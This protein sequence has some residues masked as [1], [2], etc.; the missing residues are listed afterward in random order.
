M[1]GL[2]V[3][4]SVEEPAGTAE[5]L[6]LSG[7]VATV[8]AAL[9]AQYA[10]SYAGDRYGVRGV[11]G[12]DRACL[13]RGTLTAVERMAHPSPGSVLRRRRQMI[14]CSRNFAC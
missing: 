13:D 4:S 12:V 2:A 9:R 8:V 6:L 5:A 14:R 7:E 3:G 1:A 11:R 10:W